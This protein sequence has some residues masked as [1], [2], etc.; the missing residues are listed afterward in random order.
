QISLHGRNN[1]GEIF[2]LFS[3]RSNISYYESTYFGMLPEVAMNAG[4]KLT[5]HL[6]ANLRYS[7]LM[8]IN[9]WRP[10]NQ[11]TLNNNFGMTQPTVAPPV[12]SSYFLH[13]LN[14]GL[15]FRY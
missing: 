6:T 11:I 15:T 1:A 12:R 9:D 10:G 14:P 4:F 5:E 13:G 3:A 8:T 7:G 2:D